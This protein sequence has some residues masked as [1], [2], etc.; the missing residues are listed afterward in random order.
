MLKRSNDKISVNFLNTIS[1][2]RMCKIGSV[3]VVTVLA[4][5]RIDK[6]PT[7]EKFKNLKK[8]SFFIGSIANDYE[9]GINKRLAMIGAD[10]SFI[11]DVSSVSAPFPA[12]TNGIMRMGISNQDQKYVRIYLN[13]AP[14]N[15]CESVYVDEDNKIVNLTH[16]DLEAFF[17][18]KSES[19]K[20]SEHGLDKDLHYQVRE[21]KSE[22]IIYFQCGDKI[23]NN[24]G[25]LFLKIFNLECI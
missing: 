24:L 9:S 18:K 21:F 8:V 17:P 25:P 11:S 4:K 13:V 1:G 3:T 16:E 2:S 22:N 12:S 14:N 19:K 6:S 10:P 15:Y 23:W 5:S 20:Q 7:P